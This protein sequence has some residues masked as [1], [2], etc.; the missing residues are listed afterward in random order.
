VLSVKNACRSAIQAG[1]IG[2]LG[3]KSGA[4]GKPFVDFAKGL[5][6]LVYRDY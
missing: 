1:E 2:G 3:Y 5:C 6:P 4:L